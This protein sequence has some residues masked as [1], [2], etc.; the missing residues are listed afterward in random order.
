M[1]GRM[2]LFEYHG[3]LLSFAAAAHD[4]FIGSNIEK[5]GIAEFRIFEPKAK[6]CNPLL[7]AEL[8]IW[9]VQKFGENERMAVCGGQ[10]ANL[11]EDEIAY[12]TDAFT[13]KADSWK[14]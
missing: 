12:F 13:I 9:Y 5:T 1:T 10:F 11:P 2:R 6:G 4:G 3:K 14:K 8:P 7:F